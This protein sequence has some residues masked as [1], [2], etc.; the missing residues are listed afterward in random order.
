IRRPP[1]GW[2]RWVPWSI[3]AAAM[4]AAVL[5]AR[6]RRPAAAG[7]AGTGADVVTGANELATVELRDGSVVRLAPSSRLRLSS[8]RGVEL[9]GRAFFAVAR[10]PGRPFI[11][12]TRFGAAQALSTRF[13]VA[14]R[15]DDVKLL[16]VEGR[17]ALSG[18]STRVEVAAG[19]TSAVGHGAPSQ[20]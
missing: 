7:D 4:V 10:M 19:E 16:V 18:P 15:T 14:T 6:A 1:N 13:E 20:P 17:V 9:S 11:V 5:A 2:S 8:T 3:A 12:R